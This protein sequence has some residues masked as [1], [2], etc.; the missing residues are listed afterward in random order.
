MT[1]HIKKTN[2]HLPTN[3]QLHVSLY[4]GPQVFVLAGPTHALYGLVTNLRRVKVLD[5]SKMPFLQR[6]LV[7]SVRFLDISV[8]YHLDYLVSVTEKLC[9]DLGAE[10]LWTPSELGIPVYNTEDGKYIYLQF[11]TLSH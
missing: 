6:K 7:F 2:I 8:P 1:P 9:D 11:L 10:E 4:N 3:S 5:Q